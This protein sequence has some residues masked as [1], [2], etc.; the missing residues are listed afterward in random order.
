M[1]HTIRLLMSGRSILETGE[2]IVRFEG[3]SLNLLLDI[4][5]GKMTFDEIMN[6][7]NDLM[8]DCDR[9]KLTTK[10]PPNCD[11]A[12]ADALLRELTQDWERRIA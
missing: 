10:L 9:L 5:A 8:S 12:A 3:Q 4:R 11:M 1:M 7:A 2:P 6:V